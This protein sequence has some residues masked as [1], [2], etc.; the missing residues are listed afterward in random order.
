MTG[1]E[2]RGDIE[3]DALRKAVVGF[4]LEPGG[5]RGSLDQYF[6]LSANVADMRNSTKGLL[7]DAKQY[8]FKR[9]MAH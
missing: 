7:P 1:F 5:S 4:A 6:R 2:S 3:T 8:R 9:L